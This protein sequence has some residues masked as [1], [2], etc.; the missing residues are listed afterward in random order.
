MSP[1]PERRRGISEN[2]SSDTQERPQ[3]SMQLREVESMID[4][5]VKE[6]AMPN[7]ERREKQR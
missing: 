1:S 7:S 5:K 4:I 3:S 2:V 6:G